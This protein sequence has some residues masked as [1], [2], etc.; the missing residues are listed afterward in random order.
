MIFDPGVRASA[1]SVARARHHAALATASVGFAP[2]AVVAAFIRSKSVP[3]KHRQSSTRYLTSRGV[4]YTGSG[5]GPEPCFFHMALHRASVGTDTPIAAAQA[6]GEMKYTPDGFTRG[7]KMERDLR[8][9]LT[10][11]TSFGG[12]INRGSFRW[13]RVSEAN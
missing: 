8:L 4:R 13:E 11:G 1:G 5:P 12:K 2:T 7:R 9:C 6:L 3:G 10:S